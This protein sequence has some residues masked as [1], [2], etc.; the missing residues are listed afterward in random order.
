MNWLE[1]E[2]VSKVRRFGYSRSCPPWGKWLNEVEGILRR[3]EFGGGR[4]GERD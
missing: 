1:E 2:R 4:C 3:K